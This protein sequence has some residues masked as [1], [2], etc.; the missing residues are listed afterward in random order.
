MVNVGCWAP[1]LA[2]QE[3]LLSWAEHF[4]LIFFQQ[5]DSFLS[6]SSNLF[7]SCLH[8]LA[9]HLL[10]PQALLPHEINFLH[11]LLLHILLVPNK[12]ARHTCMSVF[13]VP[14][15]FGFAIQFFPLRFLYQNE[16]ISCH[17]L[18]AGGLLR[19]GKRQV[20]RHS[21]SKILALPAT[22]TELQFGEYLF[23]LHTCSPGRLQSLKEWNS[24]YQEL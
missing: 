21:S 2:L 1:F 20:P 14:R 15:S 16:M 4:Q 17:V 23:K 9:G 6:F 19:G 24:D 18:L 7:L 10:Q 11:L 3:K 8:F 12:F 22:E 5:L 13:L